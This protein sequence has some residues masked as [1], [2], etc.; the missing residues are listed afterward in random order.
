MKGQGAWRRNFDGEPVE[1]G[2]LSA[3][4]KAQEFR[5]V[6]FWTEP[7]KISSFVFHRDF[8]MNST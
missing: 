8:E 2:E 3:L 5:H 4:Y 7:L 6:D 1:R